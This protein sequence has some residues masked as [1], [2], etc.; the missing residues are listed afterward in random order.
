MSDSPFYLL[1]DV[2]KLLQELQDQNGDLPAI[3]FIEGNAALFETKD[4]GIVKLNADSQAARDLADYEHKGQAAF[5][6]G[7]VNANS[8][9]I[10]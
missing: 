2:I 7:D 3:T 8:R 6:F 4:I 10:L 5:V 9:D 1:S